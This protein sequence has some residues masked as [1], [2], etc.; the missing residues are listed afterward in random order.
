MKEIKLHYTE[1]FLRQAARGTYFRSLKSYRDWIAP[2]FFV[3]WG[4]VLLLPFFLSKQDWILIVLATAVTCEVLFHVRMYREAM[5]MTLESFRAN[6]WDGVT[7]SYT[8]EQFTMGAPS[9]SDSTPWKH[10]TRVTRRPAY[11]AL[12]RAHK[13]SVFL[14]L[15]SLD[16]EDREF[17]TRKTQ[18]AISD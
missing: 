10:I 14:P 3:V 9:S 16:A 18:T 8:E 12:D 7:M 1:A 13:G 15:D 5:R 4:C 2:V 17:I 6:A 11:W